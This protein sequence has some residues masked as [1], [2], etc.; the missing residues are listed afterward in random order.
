MSSAPMTPPVIAFIERMN[1]RYQR[2]AAGFV[3]FRWVVIA[4]TIVLTIVMAAGALRAR[5][6]PIASGCICQER[7]YSVSGKRPTQGQ[8]RVTWGMRPSPRR[9]DAS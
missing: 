4:A 1:A 5:R 6:V 8:V 3:R 2:W 7:T 9:R